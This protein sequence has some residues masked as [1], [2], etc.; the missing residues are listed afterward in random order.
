METLES[1]RITNKRLLK[2]K[3][4]ALNS[5]ISGQNAKLEEKQVK[6]LRT[7]GL[8]TEPKKQGNWC[9]KTRISKTKEPQKRT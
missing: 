2:N 5:L 7:K 4:T 3:Q 9:G 6:L 8:R 1:V